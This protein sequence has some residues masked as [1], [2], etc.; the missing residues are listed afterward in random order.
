MPRNRAK[1]KSGLLC[2]ENRSFA[3][4]RRYSLLEATGKA[5][6]FEILHYANTRETAI[7]AWTTLD[8]DEDIMHP[9][10][11]TFV[12]RYRNH[13]G[14]RQIRGYSRSAGILSS[15]RRGFLLTSKRDVIENR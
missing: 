7:W 8:I 5:A 4:I 9:V 1:R 10:E 14:E 6:S 3:I 13:G 12:E 11:H 15:F 2:D